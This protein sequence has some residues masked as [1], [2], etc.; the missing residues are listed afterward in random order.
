MTIGIKSKLLKE[1]V[2]VACI[3]TISERAHLL[4]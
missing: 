1:I 4:L 2:H 3:M